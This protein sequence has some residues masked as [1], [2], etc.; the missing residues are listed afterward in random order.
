[1]LVLRHDCRQI[2]RLS[3]EFFYARRNQKKPAC[4]LCVATFE[5]VHVARPG[6]AAR[7][8]RKPTK[9]ASTLGSLRGVRKPTPRLTP[10]PARRFPRRERCLA[11]DAKHVAR[12]SL[13]L[14]V[15]S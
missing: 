7:L 13:A 11:F 4:S 15:I 14:R 8:G 1:L 6:T 10:R 5:Y 12:L 3:Y 2:Q 9:P